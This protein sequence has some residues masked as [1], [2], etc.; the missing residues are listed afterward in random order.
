VKLA[1]YQRA[2]V[3]LGFAA[4]EPHDA[5]LVPFSIYRQMIR[6]RLFA[7]AEVAYRGSWA[8]LGK[9]ACVASFT[10]FLALEPPRSPLIREVIGAF[11]AFAE[12]DLG[13][14][15][16][17]EEPRALTGALFAGA[18]P[19]ARDLLRF[20]AAKWRV[21]SAEAPIA[22][23]GGLRDVDFDGVLVLNPSLERLALD[24]PVSEAREERPLRDPHTLLVY[25]RR[26]DDDVRWYRAPALL[27][28]LLALSTAPAAAQT[29]VGGLVAEL[30]ARRAPDHVQAESLVQELAAALTVAVERDVL[31]GVR[32]PVPG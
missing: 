22:A 5:A 18:P 17:E 21:A 14:R 13:P 20:E 10:R 23:P 26:S 11:A 31:W 4:D 24:Y 1:A 32:E 6:A 16:Q 9:P 28:E 8:L 25:R 19:E 15:A 12:A 2:I 3:R 29:T 30:F 27:A 7:M